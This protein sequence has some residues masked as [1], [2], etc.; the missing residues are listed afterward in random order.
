MECG[1][2]HGSGF[3]VCAAHLR[4]VWCLFSHTRWPSGLNG[5]RE[6]ETTMRRRRRIS[7]PAHGLHPDV[8][9]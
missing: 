3:E 1:G 4:G 7:C 8:V 5:A 6:Q 9:A 2:G